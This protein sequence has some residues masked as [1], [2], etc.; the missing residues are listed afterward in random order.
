ML[1]TPRTVGGGENQDGL[2]TDALA[3][4]A[5]AILARLPGALMAAADD[6]LGKELPHSGCGRDPEPH[7][8]FGADGSSYRLN[9]DDGK[10]RTPPRTT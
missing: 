6:G 1:C 10:K 5:A 4:R 2:I 9:T 7:A 3:D 8:V